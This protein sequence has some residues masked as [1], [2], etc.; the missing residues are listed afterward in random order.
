MRAWLVISAIASLCVP[1]AALAQQD[2]SPTA[3]AVP[4][5]VGPSPLVG[6]ACQARSDCPES[7][8]CL[9]NICVDASEYP[10]PPTTTAPTS[11]DT[12]EPARG[13]LGL[14]LGAAAPIEWLGQWGGGGQAALRLG[15]L[16]GGDGRAGRAQ[17]QLEVS[18]ASTVIAPV[19]REPLAVF[20]AGGS[21]AYLPR[22]ARTAS[23]VLRIGGAGG[24]AFG[25]GKA[26]APFGELR[27][28]FFGA[29]VRTSRHLLVE[30]DMPS[31]RLMFVPRVGHVEVSM[32]WVSSLGIHYLF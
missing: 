17:F 3:P 18:P 29:I 14:A 19:G 30:F 21:V 32:M 7:M 16:T 15:M 4:E 1:S 6:T 10:R 9:T 11:S 24:G 2:V 8:R 23:W 12:D 13:Y 22:L 28:D 31:Y 5:R 27:L 25:S 26:L 20:E